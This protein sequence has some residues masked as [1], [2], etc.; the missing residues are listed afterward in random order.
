MRVRL[1]KKRISLAE[2]KKKMSSGK[3]LHDG[4]NFSPNTFCLKNVLIRI[5]RYI[6][7]TKLNKVKH[8]HGFV[9]AALMIKHSPF[10]FHQAQN[11]RP[12]VGF[13]Y[14]KQAQLPFT[15]LRT[16]LPR[17]TDFYKVVRHMV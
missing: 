16:V 4:N 7:V 5:D 6:L 3:L 11:V 8:S 14:P 10:D 9:C 2:G 17:K 13:G 15:T 1:V 12:Q